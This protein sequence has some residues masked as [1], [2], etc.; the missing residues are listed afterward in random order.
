MSRPLRIEYPDAWYHIMNRGRRGEEIFSGIQD[1]RQFFGILKETAGL[2]K[3][4]IAAYCLMPN[5]YH[6][7]VQTPG[8]NISRCMRHVD[9]VYTQRYNRLHGCDGQLFRGRYKSI[10]VDAEGYLFPLVRYI[11]RNPLRAG[12]AGTLEGYEWSSHRG[13]LSNAKKWDWL[14]KGFILSLFSEKKESSL[15]AYRRFVSMEDEEEILGIFGKKKWPLVLGSEGFVNWIKG[16]FYFRKWDDEVP[17]LRE[18]VPE[19]RRIRKV[20]CEFYGVNEGELLRSRRGVFNEARNV[21]IYLI[22]QL[23][24]DSLRQIGEHFQMSK[25][26]SVGS[27]VERIKGQMAE[28]RKLEGRIEKLISQVRKSQKQT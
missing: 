19:V 24:G 22:R 12:L 3:L 10:L 25:P 21:A 27:V 11:H 28:D 18:L 7:L 5:H 23:T 17:Q 20:V 4:R 15:R 14:H 2:W 13:Y 8:G 9:G 16:R 26:S 6:L 1:Y